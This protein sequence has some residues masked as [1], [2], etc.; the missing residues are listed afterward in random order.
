MIL[1]GFLGQI[2]NAP[3]LEVTSDCLSEKVSS[4]FKI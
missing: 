1:W 2:N 3:F 4:D